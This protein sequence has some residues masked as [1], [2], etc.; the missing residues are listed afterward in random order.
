[1]DTTVL[2]YSEENQTLENE[3][4]WTRDVAQLVEYFPSMDKALGLIPSTIYKR[5]CLY[6]P[7][8]PALGKW[9]QEGLALKVIFSYKMK[10]ASSVQLGIHDVLFQ[11]R[12]RN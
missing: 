6:M 12:E 4:P 1:M 9:G 3:Q 5:V 7:V 11:R 2:L 8:I 10:L